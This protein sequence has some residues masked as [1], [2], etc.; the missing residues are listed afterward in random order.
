MPRPQRSD[1]VFSGEFDGQQLSI[2][3]GIAALLR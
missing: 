2:L 1:V 3:G